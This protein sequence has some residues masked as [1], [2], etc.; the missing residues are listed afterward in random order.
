MIRWTSCR[1]V[2]ALVLAHAVPAALML[3]AEHVHRADGEH[4]SSVVHRHAA[5]HDDDA[6][7]HHDGIVLS[8]GDEHVTWLPSAFVGRETFAPAAPLATFDPVKSIAPSIV[9]TSARTPEGVARSH[10]PP[11]RPQQLRGPPTLPV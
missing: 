3:P 5:L 4:P 8:H 10:G 1:V 9:S 11:R 6:D 2:T 7:D